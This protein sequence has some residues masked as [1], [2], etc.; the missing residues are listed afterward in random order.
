MTSPA[1]TAK[2]TLPSIS[3]QGGAVQGQWALAP[4]PRSCYLLFL[5]LY[6]SHFTLVSLPPPLLP[7]ALPAIPA[8]PAGVPAECC[9]APDHFPWG[10]TVPGAGHEAVNAH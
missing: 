10:L 2:G 8:L 1:S 7:P 9:L 4:G 5:G 6:S 3:E